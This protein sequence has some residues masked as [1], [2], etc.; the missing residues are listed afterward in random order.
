MVGLWGPAILIFAAVSLGTVAIALVVQWAGE[1]RQRRIAVG[2]LRDFG[3]AIAAGPSAVLR[4][5]Q[6]AEAKWMKAITERIP[7]L[8]GLK[9]S[10]EQAA[11]QWTPQSFI[12]ISVGLAMGAALVMAVVFPVLPAVLLAAAVA[13][14][15]PYFHIRRKVKRRLAALE[16]QLP[17]AIDLIGR[18]MRAG[19]P[20]SAGLKMASEETPEPLSG[21][22]RRVFEEQR[23]GMPF[24]DAILGMCDR[25]NLIDVRILVT[26]ILVQRDV[27][28][29]LAEVL[30]KISY[31][32]RQRFTIRRQLR[33]YT[34]QGRF[35]GIV[36]A[37]LPIAVGSALFF[38]NRPY[39][40]T[41]FFDPIARYFLILAVILQ[42]LGYFWIRK[43]V[44]I[45]I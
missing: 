7:Q 42:I 15:L 23:F 5:V 3:A 17:E 28:G 31:V 4:E 14:S 40:I 39:M 36:L 27:G 10:L 44:D 34:A 8:R 43:I 38:I 9:G 18:A 16:E 2:Q 29:N 13:G 30:D 22:L 35:S 41:L 26:A 24:E 6:D 37:L 45:E 19:H 12:M 32:I 1:L 21:E 33:V 20:L 11:V 25:V